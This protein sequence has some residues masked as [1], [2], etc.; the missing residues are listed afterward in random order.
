MLPFISC[1]TI[2][3]EELF[4]DVIFIPSISIFPSTI[5]PFS[6]TIFRYCILS[7]AFEEFISKV[8]SSAISKVFAIS[9]VLNYLG[10]VYGLGNSGE[11]GVAVYVKGIIC[12]IVLCANTFSCFGC[13]A[14]MLLSI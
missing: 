10:I 6:P 9:K 12:L 8:I 7:S 13:K 11:G 3:L 4:Q 2:L 5:I 14:K 1:E